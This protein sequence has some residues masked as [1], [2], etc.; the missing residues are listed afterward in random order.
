MEK[1]YENSVRVYEGVCADFDRFVER[2]V[3]GE[4]NPQ[5]I[6]QLIG[7]ISL[8][9]KEVYILEHREVLREKMTVLQ[10]C[11]FSR[12]IDLSELPPTIGALDD[13]S[14][15]IGLMRLH[16]QTNTG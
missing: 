13:R 6:K 9:G 10:A 8:S 14:R 12:E 3:E 15:L 7:K 1:I 4:P 16:S 5:E 2:N 11:A